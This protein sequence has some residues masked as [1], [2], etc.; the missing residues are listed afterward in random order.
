MQMFMS[1]LAM[2]RGGERRA[3]AP[4]GLPVHGVGHSNG[5]LLHLLIGSL[6][7]PGNASNIII[8]FNNKCAPLLVSRLTCLTPEVL[9]GMGM[10]SMRST[11]RPWFLLSQAASEAQ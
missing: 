9:E 1:T 6:Y 8:S 7:A 11:S 5:A 2:L 3:L 4:P 10:L